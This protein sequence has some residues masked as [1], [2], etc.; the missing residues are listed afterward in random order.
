MTLVRLAAQKSPF[1]NETRITKSRRGVRAYLRNRICPCCNRKHFT[2]VPRIKKVRR[3]TYHVDVRQKPG[4]LR[5]VD[6]TDNPDLE[7]QL[8]FLGP[9]THLRDNPA[10]WEWDNTYIS[11][12]TLHPVSKLSVGSVWVIKDN[13]IRD[14][15]S[16]LSY[17]TWHSDINGWV[18]HREKEIFMYG[19]P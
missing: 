4:K 19:S 7:F 13:N 8:H 15:K 6:I 5:W 18:D 17:E 12:A 1:Y 16:H 3:K 9:D 14:D 2:V 11:E 10:H